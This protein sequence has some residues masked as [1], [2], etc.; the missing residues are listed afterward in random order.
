MKVQCSKCHDIIESKSQYDFVSCKCG[1]CFVD[2][3]DICPRAGGP[4]ALSVELMEEGL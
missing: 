1:A 2:G 3:G 4:T